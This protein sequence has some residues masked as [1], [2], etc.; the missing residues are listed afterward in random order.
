MLAPRCCVMYQLHQSFVK[1][2]LFSS[3]LPAQRWEVLSTCV[4]IKSCQNSTCMQSHL[5]VVYATF[6]L[7]QTN[8]QTHTHRKVCI[9]RHLLLYEAKGSVTDPSVSNKD[10]SSA[11]ILS[12]Q[13]RGFCMGLAEPGLRLL[14]IYFI[15]YQRLQ[16]HNVPLVRGSTIRSNPLIDGFLV[17][18][19]V[20]L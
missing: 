4:F 12:S 16:K 7:T 10:L 8:T 1:K 20:P 17:S 18:D 14:F 15:W 6:V 2:L 5:L 9:S 11:V 3:T 19:P 13:T